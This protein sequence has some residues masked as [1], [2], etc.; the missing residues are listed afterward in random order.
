MIGIKLLLGIIM[1]IN[2]TG[3]CIT[4]FLAFIAIALA[5][6]FGL[7]GFTSKVGRKV[8]QTKDDIVT[9]LSGIKDKIVKIDTN[10]D[11]LV[12]LAN[13]YLTK[14]SG[15]ITVQLKNFGATKIS[16]QPASGDTIYTIKIEHGRLD[17]ISV[18]KI[19]Q[20]TGFTNK[21]HEM[22]PGRLV[23]VGSLGSDMLRITVPSIDPDL[24]T[25][26]MSVLLK[27]LDT[28]YSEAIRSEISQFE[29]N[30]KV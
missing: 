18:A 29:D 30:I 2:I 9:G 20:R 6:Y 13:A 12:Q 23:S 10:T 1:D 21:E 3:I 19:S 26:Y 17:S 7:R 27:W 14:S 15:T 8:D 11:N 22:F 25:K 28:E 4:A 24:C 5:I 16:A